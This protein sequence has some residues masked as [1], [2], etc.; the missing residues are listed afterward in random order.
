MCC[1]AESAEQHRCQFVTL[2]YK[3]RE[4]VWNRKFDWLTL[5]MYVYIHVYLSNCLLTNCTLGVAFPCLHLIMTDHT[6]SLGSRISAHGLIKNT[7]ILTKVQTWQ[8]HTRLVHSCRHMVF[9][10]W[11]C[12]DSQIIPNHMLRLGHR[13]G[14]PHDFPAYPLESKKFE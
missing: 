14:I 1:H 4:S 7:A 6:N 2:L 10:Q 12:Y 3:L 5:Q 9:K 13:Q 11:L 8:R